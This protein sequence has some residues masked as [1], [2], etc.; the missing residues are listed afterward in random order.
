MDVDQ[1]NAAV[2]NLNVETESSDRHSSS[3]S[4]V[5]GDETPSTSSG[6]FSNKRKSMYCLKSC[7]QVINIDFSRTYT[8]SMKT[9]MSE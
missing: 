8:S 3:T 9:F 2:E 4:A 1:D 5:H 7:L 6:T